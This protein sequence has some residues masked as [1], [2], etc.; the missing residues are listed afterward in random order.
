MFAFFN[1][2][3][4]NTY[5]GNLP[6]ISPHVCECIEII[7]VSHGKYKQHQANKVVLTGCQVSL[8]EEFILQVSFCPNQEIT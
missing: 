4:N 8:K 5:F 7:T 3:N 6:D 2:N 1:N